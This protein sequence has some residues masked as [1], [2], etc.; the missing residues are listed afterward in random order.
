MRNGFTLLG[1]RMVNGGVDHDTIF[2]GRGDGRFREIQIVV[3]RAPIEL[4]DVAIT[5]G[6]GDRFEPLTRLAYG[7]DTSTRN[8]D[9]PGG[10]RVIQRVDFHYGN[11]AAREAKVEIWAR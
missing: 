4:Y 10:A 9:L 6:N 1:S 2:V 3:E 5:F 8:I 11:L 7:P